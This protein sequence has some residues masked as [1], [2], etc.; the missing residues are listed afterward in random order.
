VEIAGFGLDF[1]VKSSQHQP[2]DLYLAI[3]AL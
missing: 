3:S 1:G 2:S